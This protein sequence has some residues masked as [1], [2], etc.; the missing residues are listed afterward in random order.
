MLALEW[1]DLLPKPPKRAQSSANSRLLLLCTPA[2]V[3]RRLELAFKVQGSTRALL[4]KSELKS[5]SLKKYLT[6]P[7]DR[8]QKLRN[9]FETTYILRISISVMVP[10]CSTTQRTKQRLPKFRPNSKSCLHRGESRQMFALQVMM[11]LSRWTSSI[12]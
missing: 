6:P 3:L 12:R 7:L 10:Q 11:I 5:I 9:V 1:L 8:C 2:P 4:R